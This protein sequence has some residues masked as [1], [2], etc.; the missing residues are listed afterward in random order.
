M[1]RNLSE[2]SY[3]GEPLARQQSPSSLQTTAADA[4]PAVSVKAVAATRTDL[5]IV[6]MFLSNVIADLWKRADRR[7]VRVKS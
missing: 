3:L 5:L 1:T 7:I 6:F 4:A 2:G